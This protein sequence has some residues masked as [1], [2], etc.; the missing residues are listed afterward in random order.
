MPRI[1]YMPYNREDENI[2]VALFI[3]GLKGDFYG[4]T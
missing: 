3:F 2:Y 4:Y 1:K